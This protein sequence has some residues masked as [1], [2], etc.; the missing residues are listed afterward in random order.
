MRLCNFTN[1]HIFRSNFKLISLITAVSV[2]TLFSLGDQTGWAAVIYCPVG[3]A[4]C[5]GTRDDD[6]ITG[7]TDGAIIQGLAGNDYIVGDYDGINYIYGGDGNDILIGG[8]KNDG[9]Y[10][11]S[12][13][14]R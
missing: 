6:I 13:N 11:G 5:N 4:L 10:G 1:K 12:G 3:A 8:V 9:L 2:T 14:D 7:N